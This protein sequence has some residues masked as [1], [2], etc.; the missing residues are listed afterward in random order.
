MGRK[1]VHE[2]ILEILPWFVN[3]SLGEKERRRVL[4]HLQQCAECR[5]ERDRLQALQQIVAE[6]DGSDTADYQVPFRRLMNRIAVTETNRTSMGELQRRARIPRWAP[7][8]GVAATLV[9]ALL[10]VGVLNP[11]RQGPEEYRTLSST[12]EAP[13]VPRRIALTF[14]QP[15]KAETLRA[16]LIETGSN[17]VSGPDRNGTY[18]VEIRVPP[19]TTDSRFIQS[20]REIKGV[21]YAALEG[22]A[23]DMPR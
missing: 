10:F 17:I 5:S 12:T 11:G 19:N 1:A 14:E 3:E 16:A 18:I 15:I 4:A 9:A 7:W 6:E 13:G 8:V 21:K 20:L 2:E 22:E 23:T